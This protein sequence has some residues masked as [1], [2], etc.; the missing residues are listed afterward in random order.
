MEV[1]RAQFLPLGEA[2]VGEFK[3]RP[4]KNAWARIKNRTILKNFLFCP[5]DQTGTT[6][7]YKMDCPAGMKIIDYEVVAACSVARDNDTFVITSI[8]WMRCSKQCPAGLSGL[9]THCAA[10]LLAAANVVRPNQP[11]WKPPSTS[12]R[13]AWNRPGAG[14]VYNYMRPICFIRFTKEDIK[15]LESDERALAFPCTQSS[16]GSSGWNPYPHN[17]LLVVRTDPDV[18]AA[19][20]ALYAHLAE[21]DGGRRCAAE[22]QWPHDFCGDQKPF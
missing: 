16:L 15:D 2:L 8:L 6:Y 1:A 20:K 4:I 19:A 10:L 13:C 12:L 22:V 3:T 18:V 11:N 9:C 21:S 5:G 17:I 14:D 7:Y